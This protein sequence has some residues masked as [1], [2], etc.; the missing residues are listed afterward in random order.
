MYAGTFNGERE[1]GFEVR[2]SVEC[3]TFPVS[4]CNIIDWATGRA[5]DLQTVGC[6]FAGGDDLTGALH[7]LQ[8]QLSPPP[9]SLLQ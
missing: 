3:V 2:K 7:I 9:S 1:G 4:A 5:S 6:W 8:L